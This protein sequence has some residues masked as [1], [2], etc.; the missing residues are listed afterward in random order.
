MPRVVA[1]DISLI[2]ALY[3]ATLLVGG[4]RYIP[5]KLTCSLFG[6]KMT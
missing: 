5:L 2:T 1:W 4:P 3:F 6:E